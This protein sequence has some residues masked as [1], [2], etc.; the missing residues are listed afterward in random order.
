[1]DD[2]VVI[3]IERAR[4]AFIT[5]H[6]RLVGVVGEVRGEERS[7]DRV[8]VNICCAAT[9]HALPSTGVCSHL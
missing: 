9:R 7:D 4:S 2:A 5:E 6:I 1:M 3:A 8:L